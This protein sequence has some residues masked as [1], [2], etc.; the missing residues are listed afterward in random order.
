MN[1]KA[2]CGSVENV[3]VNPFGFR[4][5][6]QVELVN[7]DVHTLLDQIPTDTLEMHLTARKM[8]EMTTEGSVANG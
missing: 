8:E 2:V 7:V 5:T 3:R 4:S 6:F 1:I